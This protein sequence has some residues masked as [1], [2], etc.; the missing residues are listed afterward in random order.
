MQC[1]CGMVFT[2]ACSRQRWCAPDCS[3]LRAVHSRRVRAAFVRRRDRRRALE[4]AALLADTF[5]PVPLALPPGPPCRECTGCHRVLPLDGEWRKHR[6]GD[7]RAAYL[8]GR[9]DLLRSPRTWVGGCCRRCGESFVCVSYE[10]S[11]ALPGYCSERCRDAIH[12]RTDARR[13]RAAKRGAEADRIEIEVVAKRDGWKCH[14]CKRRVGRKSWS[15][16]H[17]VP[18]SDGGAHS[19]LNVALAHHLCNSKRRDVGAAQLLLIG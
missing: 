13:R 5:Q 2:P 16:D 15:I 10:K 7:C 11:R 12:R 18:L 17:L 6:C 8:R 3:V 1:A 19:Y 4:A 9:R 14:I